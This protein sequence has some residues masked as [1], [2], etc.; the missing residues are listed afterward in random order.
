MK[1]ERPS[2]LM[3]LLAL[4]SAGLVA[5]PAPVAAQVVAAP[6]RAE[7]GVPTVAAP[8]GGAAASPTGSLSA[9]PGAALS[10]PS[11]P[12]TAPAAVLPAAFAG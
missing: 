1:A 11:L 5:V 12:R 8:L 6:V 9:L 7:L 2:W 3:R 10:L 4:L